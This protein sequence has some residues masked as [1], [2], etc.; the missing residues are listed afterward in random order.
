MKKLRRIISILMI[1]VLFIGILPMN[2]GVVKAEEVSEQ[3]AKLL[4][5]KVRVYDGNTW[6]EIPFDRPFDPNETLYR[7]NLDRVYNK[8]QLIIEKENDD[9]VVDATYH[10][11]KY[12]FDSNNYGEVKSVVADKVYFNLYVNRKTSSKRMQYKI[13]NNST[14]KHHEVIVYNGYRDYNDVYVGDTVTITARM[15]N[16]GKVFDKWIVDSGDVTIDNPYKSIT[17][18]TMPDS[19][20]IIKATYKDAPGTSSKLKNIYIHALKD[21]VWRIYCVPI[22]ADKYEYE[23]DLASEYDK[24][25]LTLQEEDRLLPLLDESKYI[26]EHFDLQMNNKPLGLIVDYSRIFTE[27]ADLQNGKNTFNLSLI[28]LDGN[29]K[30]EYT[31]KVNRGEVK[32]KVR[33]NPGDG[34]GSMDAEELVK[35]SKYNL[36]ECKFEA[37]DGQVFKAWSVN[38]TEKAVGDEI[39]VDK[40]TEVTALWKDIMFKVR[41]VPGEGKGE[42][43]VKG[44][45][46]GSTYTLPDCTF[47]APENK[48]FK[49]WS[50]NNAEKAV[51]DEI[52][53]D[54]D[55]EVIALWKDIMFKVS[56]VPGEGKGENIVKDFAKGSTY[57]LPDCTFTAPE[58]KEFAGWEIGEEIKDPGE[59]ITVN[60]ETLITATWKDIKFKISLIPGEGTGE[61]IV[62][63]VKKGTDY[64]LP[65]CK[66]TAPEGQV[67][68]AWKIGDK[69]YDPQTTIRIDEETEIKAI[70][71]E[72]PD[73]PN[74]GDEENPDK[75]NPDKPNPDKPNPDKPNPDK[76]KPSEKHAINITPSPYGR[77]II[78][79]NEAKAGDKVS[80]HAIAKYG[81]ELVGLSLRDASGKLLPIINGEF[82]MPDCEVDIYPIFREIAPY[83]NPKIYDKAE[84]EEQK[85]RAR[86]NY[87]YEEENN[88]DEVKTIDKAQEEKQKE[89]KVL[90][91]IGSEILDKV[92]NGVRTLK[93]MDTKPYIN[94]GRTMLPLRYIAEALGYRVAWLSETRTAV[95]MDIGLRVEIPVDSNF[96]IVNGVKYTSDVKPEMR[97]NRI[98]LPIANIARA[99]G[100][101]DGK[102]ILWDEANRQV[103]L[104]RNFNTK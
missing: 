5:M 49:A 53:V 56:L 28:S 21:S 17:E 39:T 12:N 44:F 41:L 47:T 7:I 57:T 98:M 95:I 13:S 77:V 70:W 50:V 91:T 32:Y 99:L 94:G 46:K 55:T 79:P 3:A 9:D 101:K 38:D 43:I 52:T 23:Y 104:I 18:F 66:F 6:T 30:S 24:V 102:D 19:D 69:E 36:P 25:Y 93:A 92:D 60:G 15:G 67:F 89:S 96:I 82:I 20:V 2:L 31:L 16:L 78:D 72:N 22:N 74:T 73:K 54:K 29:S 37:P 88:E 45:A 40:D 8:I 97:N 81:Y 83:I 35:G 10:A 85:R 61:T 14:L 42:T 11:S 51:G 76:P 86:R 80:V 58:N 63:E 84:R 100:L 64:T 75:P 26:K 62:K 27:E 68:K 48:E 71:Q 59:K 103:T 1:L 90:I 4:N 65:D 87:Y 33:F 34:K